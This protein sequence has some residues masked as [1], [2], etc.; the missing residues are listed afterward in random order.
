MLYG[1]ARIS[2]RQ[3]PAARL[4]TMPGIAAMHW[5][6]KNSWHNPA[7]PSPQN[8]SAPP[9]RYARMIKFAGLSRLLGVTR[10]SGLL[11]PGCCRA[12]WHVK[13]RPSQGRRSEKGGPDTIASVPGEVNLIQISP[14]SF[15][16]GFS[17]LSVRTFFKLRSMP[18]LQNIGL[19]ILR[20]PDFFC[21]K[22]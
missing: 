10:R 4:Y 22:G 12:R 3:C 5:T 15:Y 17:G 20:L 18:A 11:G 8:K 16:H 9:K 21:R 14:I 6:C 1:I 19:R 13:R 7:H 2:R